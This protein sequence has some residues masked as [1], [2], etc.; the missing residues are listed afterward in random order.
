[1]WFTPVRTGEYEVI[2]GQLCGDGHAV[3]KATLIVQTPDE[4]EQWI[5]RASAAAKG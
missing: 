5:E 4:Y 3:M 2:C 1:M